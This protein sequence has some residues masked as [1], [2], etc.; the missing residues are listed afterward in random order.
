M[1]KDAKIY[2]AGHGGLVGSALIRALTKQGF[3]NLVTRTRA[4]LD[5]ANFTAVKEFF[6]SEKPTYVFLAAAKVGGIYANNTF[7]ADFI[8]EN[9]TIQNNVVKCAHD[10]KV[11]KLLFLGSSCIY[12]RDCPQPMK[13]EYFLTGKFEETNAP[14]AAAKIS[15]ILMCQAFHKQY[16]DTFISVMPTNLYGPNDNFDLKTSHVFPALI[17]KFYDAKQANAPSVSVWGSG[18]PK[19]EFLHVDDLA[20]ACLFL[21]QKYDAPEIINIGT[22][23]DVTIKEFAEMIKTAARY[24]GTI[25]WDSSKPDGTP[26]KLLDVTKINKLGW[27]AKISLTQ[28]ISEMLTWYETFAVKKNFSN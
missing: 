19:R 27:K 20:D 17:R 1:E 25:T 3:T 16:G 11:K 21:M 7:G 10:E 12:P 13:E 5:L 18:S 9:L 26:Q 28:G 23:V 6:S 2:V 14:Y 15:G 8:Y 24:A 4:E 22:G